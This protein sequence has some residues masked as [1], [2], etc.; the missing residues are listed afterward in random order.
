MLA[1]N[2]EIRLSFEEYQSELVKAE[3]F[4]GHLCPGMYN[5]VKMS[6]LAR[7]LLAYPSFPTKDLIVVV[8]IDRCLTD[9]I[10]SV[11]G[12]KLGR[13]TLKFRDY[14]KF[15]AT[16]CSL[17]RKQ[18]FRLAQLESAFAAMDTEMQARGIDKHHPDA[19][20]VFFDYPWQKQFSAAVVDVTFDDNDL[21]GFPKERHTCTICHEPIMDGRHVVKNGKTFC[22]PCAGT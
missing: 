5:G 2:H 12:C 4:H 14:G 7:V 1:I 15:A 6:Q 18:G 17:E 19:P 21:P 8:E 22:R 3:Q 11:T 9:A 10:C 16:F 13:R 20:R